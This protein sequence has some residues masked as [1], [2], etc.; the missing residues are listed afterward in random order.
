MV[1]TTTRLTNLQFWVGN[2]YIDCGVLRGL[3][4][5]LLVFLVLLSLIVV[6]LPLPPF[7]D[8]LNNNNNNNNKN[9]LTKC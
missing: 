7:A 6:P 3:P 2:G 5:S 9:K 4:Q 8:Q 1:C